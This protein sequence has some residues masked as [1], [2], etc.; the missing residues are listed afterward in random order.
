MLRTTVVSCV[1]LGMAG[2]L[3]IADTAT[4]QPAKLSA[5]EIVSKNVAARGGLAAWRGVQ[6]LSW[7]GKLDAGGNNEHQF[8]IPGRPAPPPPSAQ[9]AAQAQLPF[10]LEMARPRKSRWEIQFAGQTAVQVYDGK[11]G[12][13]VR[14]YLNRNEVEAFAA[15]ELKAA[16][17]QADLDGALVDYAAKGTTVELDGVEKVEGK[18]AYKLKLTLQD[19]RVLHEWIDAT[20]FLEVKLEGTP[21]KL[22]GKPHSVS[23]FLRDYRTVDGLVIPHLIETVVEGV[24][25]TEKIQIEKVV[26]NPNLDAS[27]FAKPT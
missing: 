13:K 4:A 24:Q 25:R 17:A 18:D 27:R 19:K 12:W 9:P 22:D 26:V 1:L 5:T 3:A 23:V 11:Q 15:D 8:K 7:S 14:P 6:A 2:T 20:S 21:R 10:V 16:Q